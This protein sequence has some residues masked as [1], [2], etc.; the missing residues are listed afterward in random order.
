ML[1][2]RFQ[3]LLGS[4]KKVTGT[5]IIRAIDSARQ[6]LAIE[7]IRVQI[8]LAVVVPSRANRLPPALFTA[9]VRIAS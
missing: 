8:S 1:S 5:L 7:E 9:A 2:K 4:I 3:R 6:S